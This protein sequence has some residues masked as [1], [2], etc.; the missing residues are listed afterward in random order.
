[1]PIP[2]LFWYSDAY[3]QRYPDRVEAA[4]R[5]ADLRMNTRSVFYSMTDMAGVTLQN[6]DLANLSVFSP[7][8]T[9]PKRMVLGQNK[10]FDFDVDGPKPFASAMT[11]SS[12]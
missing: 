6:P 12:K 3:A 8:F 10:V 2:M 4:R 5:N 1:L 7:T 11:G 9:S